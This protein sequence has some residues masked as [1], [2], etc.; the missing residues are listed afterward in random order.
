[1]FGNTRKSLFDSGQLRFTNIITTLKA[2][3]LMEMGNAESKQTADR[4]ASAVLQTEER[5][6][7]KNKQGM[8]K[9]HRRKQQKKCQGV[10]RTGT[11][12]HTDLHTQTMNERKK[13]WGEGGGQRERQERTKQTKNK[14]N[15]RTHK[16]KKK[17]GKSCH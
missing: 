16:K 14:T 10:K 9:K 4:Q 12:E 13:E 5:N 6:V 11:K 7:R 3:L 2:Q 17:E 8:T 1:M 15:K